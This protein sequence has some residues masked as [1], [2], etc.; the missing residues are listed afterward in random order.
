MALCCKIEPHAVQAVLLIHSA[1]L[2]TMHLRQQTQH[3]PVLLSKIR[4]LRAL[5]QNLSSTWT[6]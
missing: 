3:L 2:H 4:V 5:T 6:S 1:A